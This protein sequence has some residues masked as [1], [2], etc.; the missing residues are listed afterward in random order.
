M[1]F[2]WVWYNCTSYDSCW[3]RITW[4]CHISTSLCIVSASVRIRNHCKRTHVLSTKRTHIKLQDWKL[5]QAWSDSLS[6]STRQRSTVFHQLLRLIIK[7]CQSL[8]VPSASWY[9]L[10]MPR[11]SLHVAHYGPSHNALY[12]STTTTT[13][14]TTA[15][16]SSSKHDFY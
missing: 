5:F 1:C 7:C 14:A 13:T 4:S 2:R 3:W 11:V 10:I 6:V 12:R 9:Q 8:T 16:L 15:Q